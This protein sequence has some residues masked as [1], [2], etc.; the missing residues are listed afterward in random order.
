MTITDQVANLVSNLGLK[1]KAT[2]HPLDPLSPAEIASAVKAIKSD[3]A[4]KD[5][6]H[7][8]WFKSIQLVEPP[9]AELA[10][11]LDAWHEG[12]AGA[13]PARRAAALL[14]VRTGTSTTWYGEY[15][16]QNNY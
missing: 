14:G 7:K 9:K 15:L 4:A 10:P 5:G 1:G 3:A 2:P 8:L 13:P 12:K 11:W 6:E 16:C